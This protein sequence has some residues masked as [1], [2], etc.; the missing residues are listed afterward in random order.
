MKT[1]EEMGHNEMLD[2]IEHVIKGRL[3]HEDTIIVESLYD[4]PELKDID[5]SFIDYAVHRFD[6]NGV[7]VLNAGD[8]K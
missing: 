7:Y 2:L 1:Q 6:S 4:D 8:D 3:R 5:N